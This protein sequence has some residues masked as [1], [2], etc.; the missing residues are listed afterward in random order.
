MLHLQNSTLKETK[1]KKKEKKNVALKE[2][3]KLG[4]ISICVLL[5]RTKTLTF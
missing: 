3:L 4:F 1:K 2:K 5:K